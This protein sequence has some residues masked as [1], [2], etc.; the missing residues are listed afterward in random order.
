MDSGSSGPSQEAHASPSAT[1]I[2]SVLA[3]GSTKEFSLMQKIE[4]GDA[5]S[6]ETINDDDDT[7]SLTDS[8]RQHIVEGGLRYHAY[9]SGSYVF[10][11][12]ETE[13]YREDMKHNLCLHLCE[14]AYFYA[15][16]HKILEKG[17]TVLDLGV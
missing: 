17:A 10:P 12:D 15:P 1:S 4:R 14:G 11:N 6:D 8:I 5:L 7:K 13:Q 9:H 3:V 2:G 16:V